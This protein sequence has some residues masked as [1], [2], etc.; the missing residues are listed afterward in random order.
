MTTFTNRDYAEVV[1]A[2]WFQ[3]GQ[4]NRTL[5]RG[6]SDTV[7]CPG[8]LQYAWRVGPDRIMDNEFEKYRVSVGC[9]ETVVLGTGPGRVPS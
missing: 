9:S 4:G 3:S 2:F 8:T 7:S 6:A 1:V 5:A